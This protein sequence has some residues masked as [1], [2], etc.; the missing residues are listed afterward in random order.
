MGDL[1]FK[2]QDGVVI[3]SVT[4]SLGTPGIPSLVWTV[5]AMHSNFRPARQSNNNTPACLLSVLL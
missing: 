2:M 5:S 4:P 1:I 3:R